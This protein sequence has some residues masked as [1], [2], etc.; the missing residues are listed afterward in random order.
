M[1]LNE[2]L[3]DYHFSEKHTILIAATNSQVLQAI[4]ELPPGE[5]SIIF[6]I[7]FYIRSI[8]SKLMG[9]EFMNFDSDKPLIEQM[10]KNGFK[11]LE[12]TDREVIIGT[13]GQHRKAGSPAGKKA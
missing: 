9:K 7:L 13:I 6:N 11:I 8:P 3:P 1:L 5:I 4:M 2:Y 12:K 10:E